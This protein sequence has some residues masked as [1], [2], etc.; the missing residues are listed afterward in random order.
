MVEDMK[1]R[2]LAEKTQV[3]YVHAVKQLA[4]HY[5]KSPDLIGDEELR[6]YFVHL[7]EVKRSAPGSVRVALYGVKF[8]FKHT[9]RRPWPTLVLQRDFSWYDTLQ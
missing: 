7:T 3:A 2:G 6:Q 4:E 5:G 1:L 9:L 8:F